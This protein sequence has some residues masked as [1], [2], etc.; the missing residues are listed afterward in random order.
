MHLRAALEQRAQ[1]GAV[2]RH[3]DV[4]HG[5]E[6]AGAG[7][8]AREQRDVALRAG[9]ELRV[10][11]LGEAQLLQRAQAVRVAVEDVVAG[12]RVTW[13]RQ[14]RRARR[15]AT[16][17]SGVASSPIGTRKRPLGLVERLAAR[18]LALEDRHAS[19]RTHRRRAPRVA[20][21]RARSDG[22]R[23]LEVEQDEGRVALFRERAH[24]LAIAPREERARPGSRR[25]P[26]R[27]PP[28]RLA[29][30]ARRSAAS[31]RRRRLRRRSAI[32]SRRWPQAP[33]G[34]CARRRCGCATRATARRGPA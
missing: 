3:R 12:H 16:T 22:V 20:A 21:T 15:A 28:A 9:D 24:A 31:P 14:A 33:R 30:G 25:S 10:D 26:R 11:R 5:H 34:A 2:H 19:P 29:R 6:V 13:R 7:R 17:S 18:E 4:E 8:D 23:H 32:P 27:A 1:R